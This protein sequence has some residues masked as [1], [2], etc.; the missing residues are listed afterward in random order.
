[1]KLHD[2]TKANSEKLK[3][4]GAAGVVILGDGVQAIFGT[5]SEN[6]KTEMEE[7]LKTAGP[8]ADQVEAPRP[9]T[10]RPRLGSF[11][12]YAIRTPRSKAAAWI[13]ALGGADNIERVDDCAET[14][15][16]VVIREDA[17][18]DES[19]LHQEG[20]EAVIRLPN[21][22]LHLLVGLNADQYAAE[23]KGQLA[24]S[25]AA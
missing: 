11:Q 9:C 18:V 12:N 19:K 13:A 25:L 20:I 2:V 6:L 17:M 7:Y 1:M 15:L 5:R 16:R 14:R 8:E 24:L 10:L 21:K 4:L 23:M 22:I 3:A